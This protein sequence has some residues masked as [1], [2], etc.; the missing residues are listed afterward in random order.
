MRGGPQGED[1]KEAGQQIMAKFHDWV[2]AGAGGASGWAL[3][4]ENHE[5]SAS[6]AVLPY[7]TLNPRTPYNPNP[8]H[9]D[10]RGQR[11][12][13]GPVSDPRRVRA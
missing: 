12:I 4:A 6:C 8:Q 10:V 11:W 1:Y 2:E 9:I 3:E 13:H 7:Q 5:V